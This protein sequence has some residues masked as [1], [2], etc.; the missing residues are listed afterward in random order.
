M[1]NIR[2]ALK[3]MS[4]EDRKKLLEDL[5]Q[6]ERQAAQE[7]RD[8]YE[9][10]RATFMLDVKNKLIPVVEEVKGFRDWIEKETEAF[11]EMMREYGQLRKEDQ[12]SFTLVDG[13]MKVEVRS[14]NVK[15]FD[16]RANMAAERLVEYL[17]AW[18]GR[19][20]KG[21]D[22]PMYQLAM[23]LLERNKQG[24]LDYKSVSK[25]YELEGRFDDEYKSIMDLFR[26]SN[27]VSKTAI[28]YYF[29]QRDQNGVWR[30]IE[31]SFCRM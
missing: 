21:Q 29:S 2:E 25:L 1:D 17:K 20:D 23:T 13:D 15:T 12:L 27:V 28:N 16:E 19:S 26:E 11:R 4:V 9:A 31:P 10:V 3:G 5:K 7:R 18:V 24:D 8:A 14:N 6:E 22:D 30:R